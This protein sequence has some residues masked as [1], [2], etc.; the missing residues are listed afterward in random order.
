MKPGSVPQITVDLEKV[1]TESWIYLAGL[2]DGEGCIY[3]RW[4][5]KSTATGCPETPAGFVTLANTYYPVIRWVRETF[6]GGIRLHSRKKDKWKDC[7]CWWVSTRLTHEILSRCVKHLKIKERQA[8]LVLKLIRMIRTYGGNK[9][10]PVS[11]EEWTARE[12]LIRQ[13]GKLNQK[14][15]GPPFVMGDDDW[16]I[17]LCPNGQDH[18]WEPISYKVCGEFRY[19]YMECRRCTVGCLEPPEGVVPMKPLTPIRRPGAVA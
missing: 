6:G 9:Y 5:V 8:R 14:G 4:T 7:Y 17:R 15:K 3:A 12:W 10:K 18:D 1:P 13:V 16:D 11:H 19:R 2:I